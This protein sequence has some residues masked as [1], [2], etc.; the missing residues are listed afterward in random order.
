MIVQKTIILK[1]FTFSVWNDNNV[2][3][4]YVYVTLKAWII[5]YVCMYTLEVLVKLYVL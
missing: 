5:L 2:I 3:L 1:T 4:I